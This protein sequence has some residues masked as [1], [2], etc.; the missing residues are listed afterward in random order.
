MRTCESFHATPIH[1][2]KDRTL[3]NSENTKKN[4]NLNKGCENNCWPSWI[5]F[6]AATFDYDFVGGNRDFEV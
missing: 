3:E 1:D 2:G 4:S 6:L 5:H